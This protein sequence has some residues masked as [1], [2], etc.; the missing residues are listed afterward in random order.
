MAIQLSRKRLLLAF[1]LLGAA[2][3]VVFWAQHGAV[4]PAAA[5]PPAP[6]QT[7]T[8]AAAVSMVPADKTPRVIGYIFGTEAITREELGEYLIA[9]EG[10]E[11]VDNLVNRRI[12]EH[13][14]KQK[15]FEVTAAEV[16]ADFA[17]T[18]RGLQNLREKDFVDKIL[19]PYHKTLYEWK[20]DVIKPRLLLSKLC[21]DRVQ[22]TDEDLRQ[23][24]EAY[25]GEKVQ[26]RMIM[27]PK[28]EMNH[29]L[30][31]I[32]SK[33]RDDEHAFEE[34]AKSQASHELAA[35]G[36][37]VRPISHG[38]TGNEELEKVAFA[39]RPNELS[40]V[41]DTPQ[42]LV[43]LKCIKHIPPETNVTLE[44]ERARLSKEIIEK[45]MQLEIPKVFAELRAQAKPEIFFK[46][47]TT[48]EELKRK[49]Q[50]ELQSGL[51]AAGPTGRTKGN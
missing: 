4:P 36:G 46:S 47:Q 9:R 18:L 40:R 24:F 19:K 7:P 49:A 11:R 38:T 37:E 8:T 27:W 15:G 35:R 22:V 25:H 13:I 10:Q 48:E 31:T 45:K 33:I 2:A 23:A 12:I 50:E 43:V 5:Q 6:M 16:E 28:S 30:H 3:A 51:N 44:Q 21:R 41:I 20:E 26:C 39:L 42:G 17:E 32:Y 34:A 1:G 29:V 14:C